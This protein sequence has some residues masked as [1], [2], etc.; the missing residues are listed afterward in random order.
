MSE[1][2]RRRRIVDSVSIAEIIREH[3]D[4]HR[5]GPVFRSLCPFHDDHQASLVIDPVAERFKCWSCGESGD[6][7]DFLSRTDRITAAKAMDILEGRL[8]RG[9][10]APPESE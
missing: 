9:G 2:E 5:R 8:R 7:V 3:L 10:P 1:A 6:V 4:I